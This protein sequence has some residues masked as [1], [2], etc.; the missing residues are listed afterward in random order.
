MIDGHLLV[1]GQLDGPRELL[2]HR[3]AHAAAEEREL[4]DAQHGR[5]AADA[6]RARVITASCMDGLLLGGLDAIAVA[7]GVLEAERVDAAERGLVL[8]EGAGVAQQADAL[9]GGDAEGI[10]ALG[11][12]APGLLDLGPV[13]DLLARLALDPQPLGDD[14][15]LRRP[16]GLLLR[17]LEPGGHQRVLSGAFREAMKSPTS[18]RGRRCR[19]AP[20]SCARWPS[21]RRRRRR[22]R[23]T[24][25][26][27]L[28]RGDAE[29]D[30]N[31][32]GRHQRAACAA[33]RRGRAAARGARAGHAG[34][35]DHVDEAAAQ[36][37][38]G[39]T[40]AGVEVGRHHVDHVEAGRLRLGPQRLRLL[41]GQVGHDHAVDARPRPRSRAKA[42]RPK[43]RI[44]L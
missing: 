21:P 43:A 9:A 34:E 15:L 8:L 1:D 31:G 13:H 39:R 16:L 17:P 11:A 26:H 12:H 19:R 24:A 42:L 4:E 32:L 30:A 23:P 33:G 38:D 44:G 3:R 6:R 29:A 41:G 20:R 35:R 7:L 18:R 27:L 5:V 22:A 2:A 36:P 10:V 28:G 37:G 40:R 25:G 14:D